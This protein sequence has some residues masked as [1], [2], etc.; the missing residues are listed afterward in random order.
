MP[1]PY[2]VEALVTAW[3]GRSI[4]AGVDVETARF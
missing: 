2:H 1:I 3:L 4:S